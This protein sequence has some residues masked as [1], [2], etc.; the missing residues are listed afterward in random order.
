MPSPGKTYA[1]QVSPRTDMSRPL[2]RAVLGLTGAVVEAAVMGER[3]GP[4]KITQI[5]P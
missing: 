2:A 4:F 1:F 3:G 5:T